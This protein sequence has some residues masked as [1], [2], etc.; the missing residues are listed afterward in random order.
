M[1]LYPH[2]I[3]DDEIRIIQPRQQSP[4]PEEPEPRPPR[5]NRGRTIVYWILG[6][7]ALL[8]VLWLLFFGSVGMAP[9]KEEK[10]CLAP[11][12]TLEETR[13]DGYV[14]LRDT[15]AG[16]WPLA[17]MTPRDATPELALGPEAL[18]DSTAVLVVQAA[19][20]RGDNGQVVGAYV[21]GGDLLSKGRSKA[22]FCAIIDGKP[23]IGVADNTPYLEQAIE[24][25]GDFFRQYPLVVSG[26]AVDNRLQSTS[27]RKALAE[28]DGETVVVMSR[29]K[30]TLNQFAEAL[31]DL[32]VSN[33][34]YLV[35]STAYG[36]AR[37]RYGHRLDFGIP[38]AD[39]MPNTNYI[40]WR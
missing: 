3:D 36:F 39:P 5:R 7:L 35:G 30:M 24:T 10:L 18:A 28:L 38:V 16:G 1:S 22:G 15:V 37:D 40:V 29:D 8:L 11:P 6:S 32:G 21:L 12:R 4:E 13:G 31:V 26:Q 25:G 2:D 19:D 14:D 27:L 34:I 17:V 23:T 20:V 33:A 9:P